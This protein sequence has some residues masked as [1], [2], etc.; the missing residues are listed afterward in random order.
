MYYILY[1]TTQNTSSV[2]KE[3]TRM[4]QDPIEITVQNLQKSYKKVPVLKDVTF[5]IEKDTMVFALLGSNGAGKTTTIN[6]LTTLIKQDGGKATINGYDTATQAE[7]V[8]KEI[9]LTGQFAA[10][11][12]ALTAKENLM[13]IAELRD[14]KSPN[15]VADKLLAEFDLTDAAN[16]LAGTFSGG[17]RRRLDIAMSLIGSPSVIFLDEPTT[18]LDP[19][20]RN[21]MWEIIKDLA[22]RG[23][24]IFM[25]TQYLEEADALADKIA[26][27]HKGR[28]VA[29]GTAADLKKKLPHGQITLSFTDTTNLTKAEKLLASYKPQRDDAACALTV[30]TGGSVSELATLLNKIEAARLEVSEFSQK[31]PTL[32]DAF[33]QIINDKET[34]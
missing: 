24:T 16:R 10:V 34:K 31:T 20:S 4:K 27:L 19:Q 22:A 18:G 6:I 1:L 29:Q 26:V 3:I 30:S 25:T 14:Q 12:E 32:D 11:D 9:S 13:L 8:R 2:T 21:N 5:A 28:I 15:K 33:F 23:V 7:N 17:M